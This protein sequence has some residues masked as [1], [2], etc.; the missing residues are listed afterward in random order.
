LPGK[1]QELKSDWELQGKALKMRLQLE[2]V[3]IRQKCPKPYEI[4]QM[5]GDTDGTL[6]SSSLGRTRDL[7]I[8]MFLQIAGTVLSRQE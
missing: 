6:Y 5:K 4:Q 3:P 7:E 1:G 2:G 8:E